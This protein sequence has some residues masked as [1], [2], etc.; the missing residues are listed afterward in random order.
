MGLAAGLTSSPKGQDNSGVA[1]QDSSGL[2]TLIKI[3]P[4]GTE[5]FCVDRSTVRHDEVNSHFLQFF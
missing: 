3:C 4:V 5:F 1:A 2:L